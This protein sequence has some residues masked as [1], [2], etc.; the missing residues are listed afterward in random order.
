MKKVILIG[1]FAMAMVAGKLQAQ[2]CE[3]IVGAR[4]GFNKAVLEQMPLAKLD[5]YCRFSQNTFF[6]ADA[7]P[8]G[9]RVYSITEVQNV[10]TGAYL[11]NDFV[12]NMDSLSIYE[13]NFRKFHTSS[14]GEPIYYSTPHSSKP[15]LGVRSYEEAM[16][17]TGEPNTRLGETN[18][19]ERR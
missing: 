15:Y 10:R 14:E 18:E 19:E 2:D 11:T 4:Y 16:V 13:Y 1:I 5:W 17:M 6:E 9:A 8:E 3:Y 7:V 12:V